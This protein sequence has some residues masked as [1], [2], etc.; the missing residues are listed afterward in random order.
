LQAA[1]FRDRLGLSGAKSGAADVHVLA[2]MVRTH[3]HEPQPV[4][5]NS[6]RAEAVKVVART[7]KTMIWERTHHTQRLRHALRDYFPAALEAFD[8]LDAA[9]TVELLGQAPTP[10]PGRS[11]DDRPDQRRDEAGEPQEHRGQ[12]S[13]HPG[14]AARRPPRSG[15]WRGPVTT[16]RRE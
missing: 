2:D 10:N 9:N 16:E 15:C 7:Y 3:A 13:A 14:R 5:G 6:N 4:A 12:G 8:D 11:A 1:R